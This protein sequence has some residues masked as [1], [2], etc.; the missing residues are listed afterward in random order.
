MYKKKRSRFVVYKKMQYKYAILTMAL[1]VLYTVL[2]LTAIFAPSIA[3]FMSEELS[4]AARAEAANAFLLLNRYMWP[5]IAAIILLFG[6]LSLFVTHRIAGPLYVMG[7][8]INQIAS[9]QLTA[10]IR[11]RKSD[12]LNEFEQSMNRMAKNLES[13][14][15]DLDGRVRSL[16]AAARDLAQ[17]QDPEKNAKLLAEAGAIVKI[18]EQYEFGKKRKETV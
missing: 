18:M 12:D 17:G 15:S 11:M 1:L 14:M 3:I 4:I 16:S 9:G 7:L 10:R 13:S 6:V 8:M 2:L 5:G